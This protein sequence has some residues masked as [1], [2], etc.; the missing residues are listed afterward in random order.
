MG[1]EH[2]REHQPNALRRGLDGETP[3][4]GQQPRKIVQIV[5]VVGLDDVGVGIRRVHVERHVEGGGALEDRPEPLVVEEQTAPRQ[6]VDHGALEAELVDAALE[7]VGV[8]L[9]IRSRQRGETLEAIGIAVNRFL[10]AVVD[11]ARDTN[12]GLGIELLGRRCGVAQHLDVDT[13][14][15]HLAEAKL[16]QIVEAADDM[17]RRA[18]VAALEQGRRLGIVVMLL[19]RDDLD[20]VRCRHNSPPTK[21]DTVTSVAA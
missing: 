3:A 8:G 10:E 4:G 15:V 19:A 21:I 14:L 11:V 1:V 7:L 16:A 17:G 6:P 12:G 2:T 5:L 20:V 18:G 9:R 13:A